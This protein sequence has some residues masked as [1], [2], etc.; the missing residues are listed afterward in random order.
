MQIV[1]I[2][3]TSGCFGCGFGQVPNNF[4][5]CDATL[6]TPLPKLLDRNYKGGF[7]PQLS[8]HSSLIG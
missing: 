1:S 3:R 8:P 5:S 7:E 2:V 4:E 6:I